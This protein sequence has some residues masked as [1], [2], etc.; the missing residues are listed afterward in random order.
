[1]QF[2]LRWL[3]A[4]V[5]GFAAVAGLAR[6]SVGRAILAGFFG[7]LA[8]MLASLAHGALSQ[9]GSLSQ[10]QGVT[11]VLLCIPTAILAFLVAVAIIIGV[12]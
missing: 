11:L 6:F 9:E 7:G 5:A 10:A 2:G 4:V 3:L 1:V 12:S 8:W